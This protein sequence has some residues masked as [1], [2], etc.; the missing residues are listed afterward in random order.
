[1]LDIFIIFIIFVL[2]VNLTFHVTFYSQ[3]LIK[4]TKISLK[5]KKLKDL[6]SIQDPK[7]N[8]LE[9]HT[10]ATILEPSI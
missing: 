6:A 2:I 7:P 4:R 3:H 5:N 9:E 10:M 8:Q 1:M